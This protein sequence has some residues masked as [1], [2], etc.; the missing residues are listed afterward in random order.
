MCSIF[1]LTRQMEWIYIIAIIVILI[2]TVVAIFVLTSTPKVVTSGL[3][4]PCC[5]NQGRYCQ[6]GYRCDNGFCKVPLGGTCQT[7]NDCVGEAKDC[8]YPT[9]N[10]LPNQRGICVAEPQGKLG[11]HCPCA[12]GFICDRGVCKV[13]LNGV[14]QQLSDC[15]DPATHCFENRCLRN[16]EGTNPMLEYGEQWPVFNKSNNPCSIPNAIIRQEPIVVPTQPIVVP[17]TPTP[18]PTPIP[19]TPIVITPEPVIPREPTPIPTPVIPTPVIPTPIP[20]PVIPREPTP[21]I[22]TPIPV[23]SSQKMPCLTHSPIFTSAL[24]RID[25]LEVDDKGK[26]SPIE[27]PIEHHDRNRQRADLSGLCIIEHKE[28]LVHLYTNDKIRLNRNG[29]IHT[30]RSNINME[31]IVSFADNIYGLSTDGCLYEVTNSSVRTTEWNWDKC[32]WAPENIVH[33]SASQ[34]GEVIWIQTM[35]RG[36]LYNKNKQL[37]ETSASHSGLLRIYGKDSNSYLTY[38]SLSGEGQLNNGRKVSNCQRAVLLPN[39]Q[40]VTAP[41]TVYNMCYARGMVYQ[42]LGSK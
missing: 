21:V 19:P 15:A 11:Q 22:P 25:I 26:S 17:R 20:T 32:T 1:T 4:E 36:L 38:N 40:V 2:L 8:R 13:P 10:Q 28:D 23:E 30:I 18:L 35:T 29:I 34:D 42:M 41:S 24:T 31:K 33:I 16:P 27:L 7:L 37:V 6:E 14:C 5:A 12:E 3:N 9:D 39:N